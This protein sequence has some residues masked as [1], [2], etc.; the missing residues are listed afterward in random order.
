MVCDGNSITAGLISSGGGSTNQN[1][2]PVVLRNLLVAD[3]DPLKAWSVKSVAAAGDST[4]ERITKYELNGGVRSLFD[5]SYGINLLTFFEATN[6][7]VTHQ[8]PVDTVISQ[9]IQYSELA[10]YQGWI[11]QLITP[12]PVGNVAAN[13]KITELNAWLRTTGQQYSSLPVLD[14]AAD[15]RLANPANNTYFQNDQIHP[16]QTGYGVIAELVRARVITL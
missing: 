3:A 2:W 4:S 9:I 11:L 10:I 6:D 16:N 7:F 12:T 15:V 1:A 13:A 14:I 8:L 5:P